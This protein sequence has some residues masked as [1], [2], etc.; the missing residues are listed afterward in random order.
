MNFRLCQPSRKIMFIMPLIHATSVPSLGW[1]KRS[2]W[3][4]IWIRLGSMT[5]TKAPFSL[6]L[7]I[8]DAIIG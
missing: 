8:R 2:E 4:A 1:M 3:L 7:M 6:A 5:M